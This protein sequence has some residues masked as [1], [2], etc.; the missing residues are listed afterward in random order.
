MARSSSLHD[1]ADDGE[2]GSQDQVVA[3]TNLIGDNTGAKSTNKTAALQ[4]GNDVCLKVGERDLVTGIH[5]R[6][7][8]IVPVDFVSS[9]LMVA[10][11]M[12][13]LLT[14]GR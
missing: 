14:L 3:A 12:T 10:L 4:G 11:R 13:M 9:S 6:L 1:S 5:E 2:D 8:T 7:E